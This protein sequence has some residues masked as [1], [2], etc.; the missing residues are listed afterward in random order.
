[1]E[2]P[3]DWSRVVDTLARELAQTKVQLAMANAVIEQLASQRE[4]VADD[5]E[6]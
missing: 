3:V 5:S 4:E 2:F 1:M 6:S